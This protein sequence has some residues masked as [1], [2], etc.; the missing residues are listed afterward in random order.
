MEAVGRLAGG[1]AHDFNNLLTVI[2]GYSELMLSRG[3]GRRS[4]AQRT[5]RRS[6][7]PRE[8]AAA[9]TRQLLAFSRKQ[10]FEPQ[11]ARPRTTVVSS[12]E[13]MLARAHRRGRRIRTSALRP[14]LGTR[15]G[16]PRAARAGHHESR[17][18]RPR[19]HADRRQ[20]TIETANVELDEDVRREHR[21]SRTGRYVMLAVS[22]TGIGMDAGDSQPHLRALLH[23]QGAG[24][25]HRPRPR[26]GLRHRQAERRTHRVYSELGQGTTFKVY[27]P[28]VAAARSSS[29]EST[30][31]PRLTAPPRVATET[32]LLVED[33]DGVRA[34]VRQVLERDGYRVIEARTGSEALL[35][36][37]KFDE[38]I[39]LL[40]TDVV[41]AQM[42]G[43]E[44]A[45]VVMEK[46]KDA[47][48][49]FISG[50]TEEAIV[51]NGVLE[52]GTAFLQKP[53]TPA[54]L[55][56]RVRE[57]LHSDPR[58]MAASTTQS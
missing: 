5:S 7:R 33:E 8:R 14:T 9:L 21:T 26:D 16:R 30:A 10:V 39:D 1:V 11:R 45:R 3:R 18:Q 24:Q 19:R 17:G 2:I 43:R 51:R 12:I 6:A 32:V 42:S 37:E 40:L 13:K 20:L 34:L 46:R 54:A 25:G 47:K 53:F 28:V 44:I 58:S 31:Q 29:P 57:I 27:L 35:A 36:S 22:D 23:H 55:S 38:K 56:R 48:V 49:L 50:Y 41:L 4:H 15:E 52:S